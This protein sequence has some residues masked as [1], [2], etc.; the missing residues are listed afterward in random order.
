MPKRVQLLGSGSNCVQTA[1]GGVTA[2][3]QRYA[4]QESLPLPDQLSKQSFLSAEGGVHELGFNLVIELHNSRR[5]FR[6]SS[7]T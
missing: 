7:V 2:S 5:R 6:S 4:V 3:R 1:S